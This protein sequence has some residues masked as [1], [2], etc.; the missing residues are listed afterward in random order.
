MDRPGGGGHL[1]AVLAAGAGTDRAAAGAQLCPLPV[2]VDEY[3]A[4]I[5]DAIEQQ[6][7]AG[8]HS[9]EMGEVDGAVEPGR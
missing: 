2:A 4:L 6:R 7:R 8:L 1:A 3:A 5:E 9:F